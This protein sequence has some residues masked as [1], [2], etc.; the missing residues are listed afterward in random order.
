MESTAAYDISCGARDEPPLWYVHREPVRPIRR[1]LAK[2]STRDWLLEAIYGRKK[3]LFASA[4]A[5]NQPTQFNTARVT[6]M[7]YM[8][9]RALSFN[10]L[11]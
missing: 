1:E 8:F 9:H 7:S 5:L 10:Q 6:N 4:Y 3:K 11:L 2:M